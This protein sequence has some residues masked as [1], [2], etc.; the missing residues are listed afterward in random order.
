[1]SKQHYLLQSLSQSVSQPVGQSVSKSGTQSPSRSVVA[2]TVAGTLLTTVVVVDFRAC[3]TFWVGVKSIQ[4]YTNWAWF[5]LGRMDFCSEKAQ[6]L[7]SLCGCPYWTLLVPFWGNIW[8]CDWM[9]RRLSLQQQY[10]DTIFLFILSPPACYRLMDHVADIQKHTML[11]LS[12]LYVMTY[13]SY[14][15]LHGRLT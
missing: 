8:Y 5:H 15:L 13:C 7:L 3:C 2:G 11:G 1:M 6:N 9:T 14:M 12:M 10:I 4:S